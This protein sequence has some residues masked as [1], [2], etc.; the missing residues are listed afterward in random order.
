MNA[1]TLTSNPNRAALA[2]LSREELRLIASIE[3]ENR[4]VADAAASSPGATRAETATC[5][6]FVFFL[7]F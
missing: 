4:G 5:G 1:P 6:V 2:E 3:N 7:P